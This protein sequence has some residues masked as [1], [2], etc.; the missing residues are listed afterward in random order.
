ML[1]EVEEAEI[2]FW[3]GKK[4]SS[5]AMVSHGWPEAILWYSAFPGG[6]G[7]LNGGALLL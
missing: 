4:L 7:D 3:R 1:N 5:L 2:P 6:V